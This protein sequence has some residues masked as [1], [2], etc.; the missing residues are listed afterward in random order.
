MSETVATPTKIKVKYHRTKTVSRS[1]IISGIVKLAT[2]QDI[3]A[4]I[5]AWKIELALNPKKEA[6][7]GANII[8]TN[9]NKKSFCMLGRFMAK[10]LVVHV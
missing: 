10:S 4:I 2:Y 6:I 3:N 9:T 8:Q 5:S 1:S 7:Y